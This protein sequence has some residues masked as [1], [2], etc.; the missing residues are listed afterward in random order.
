M[1]SPERSHAF[2]RRAGAAAAVAVLFPLFAL[3]GAAQDPAP[4]P[5]KLDIP[6][7]APAY[8]SRIAPFFAA[9]CTKCHGAE[10][11]KGSLRLDGRD[12]I[13]KGGDHGPVIAQGDA[14]ASEILRRLRLP[15]DDERHMPPKDKAQPAADDIEVLEAWIEARAPFEDGSG[16]EVG[17]AASSAAGTDPALAGRGSSPSGIAPIPLPGPAPAEALAALRARL[18]H[19]EPLAEG[20]P[21]LVVE[22]AA[23]AAGIDDA[24]ATELLTPVLGQV[25]RL[26][27][28]RTKVTDAALALAARMPHLEQLDLRAT[29]VTAAG[30]SALRE[31]PRLAEI[32]LARTKVSDAALD[33]F[34]AMPA[35]RRVHVWGSGI[36]AAAVAELRKDRPSLRVDAGDAEDAA[37]LDVESAI[38]LTS[39]APPPGAK[40]PAPVS[41][42]SPVPVNATCPVSDKAVDPRYVIL[43]EGRAIGFC[44]PNCPSAFWRSPG[45]FAAKLP[46]R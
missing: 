17:A 39:D 42:V 37:A 20:D 4:R 6:A 21:R 14:A 28:A 24:A 31:H 9:Y 34:R 43:F 29:A 11:Q 16:S 40:P 46:P 33:A 23:P 3:R 18:V 30:L 45:D 19:V 12:G 8:A 22:C 25:A 7:A 38:K 44:C 41:P 27:L 15:V 5:P 13:L 26:S 10:R 1:P 2:R 35:L 32:V 36:S